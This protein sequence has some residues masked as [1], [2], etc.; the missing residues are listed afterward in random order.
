M[1]PW[2]RTLARRYA[3]RR[4]C[5]GLDGLH[6]RGLAQT[7]DLLADSP[8]LLAANH[9]AWW[10]A[11]LLLPLDEALGGGGRAL[12]DQANLNRMPF[13]SWVGAIPLD[14]SSPIRSRDGL[15][16]AAHHL[17]DPGSS[18]WIFPQGRQRPAWLRPLQLQ[19]GVRLVASLSNAPIVPVSIQY[20]F[21]EID[22]PAAVVDFGPPLPAR[23]PLAKL[24]ETICA[25][26]DRIDRF[27]E[28]ETDD[29]RPLLSPPPRRSEDHLGTRLLTLKH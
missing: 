26:L 23:S 11:L 19:R 2:F 10:D 15:R 25:G 4:I 21:R 22:R 20:G 17:S 8:V 29:Y 1:K 7:R 13:F 9:V 16:T 18:L 3:R 5:R 12:M 27:F 28:G 24:E 14:R 6:V